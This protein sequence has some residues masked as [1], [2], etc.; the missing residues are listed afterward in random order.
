MGYYNNVG[1]SARLKT[2]FELNPV[3]E[4]KQGTFPFLFPVAVLVVSR[5]TVF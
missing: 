4:D 3:T 1:C 5:T 2:S